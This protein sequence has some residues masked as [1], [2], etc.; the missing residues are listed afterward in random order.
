[1]AQNKTIIYSLFIL[2]FISSCSSTNQLST[3]K[4]EPDDA[5]PLTYQSTPS[6]IN[7]PITVQIKD[8]ENQTNT[9]LKGLIYED[10]DITDDDIEM[11]VWKTASIQMRNV[12]KNSN[13]KLETVLPLKALIKYRIGTERLGLKMYDVR[14]F[15]LTGT[16]ILN[17]DVALNNWKLRTKTEIKSL[18]WTESPTMTVFGKNMPITYL[19]NP[20][21]SLFKS[22]ITTSI[23]SAIEKAMDFKPNVLAALE[24]ICTPFLMNEDYESWLRI[25]PT[26]IY[27]TEA[28]IKKDAFML[29][30]GVKCTMETIIGKQPESKFNAANIAI[31]PVS[32]IPKQ[33]N[34]SIAAISTYSAASKIMSKNFVGQE[35]G[36]G[37]KKV[38]VKNVQLWHKNGK[39][40][41]ALDLSGSINGAIYLSG[42]PQYNSATKELYFDQLDYVLDT[43][44]KLT[45]T[46]NWLMQ[47]YI[48]KKIQ[49]SCRYSIAPNL[50]EGKQTMLTYLN[51]YSPM[52]GVFV[53][54]KLNEIT[55]DKLKLT[56]QAI[57]AFLKING[58]V[59]ISVDGLE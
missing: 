28:S 39:M 5:T 48:L 4:P 43:K 25:A 1:M 14:E 50:E 42:F 46:A 31:K 41:I 44:N 22:D 17:S 26:E 16:V 47:G 19:A 6:F 20:A 32:K 40:I 13:G 59:N 12:S 24:Q 56:N 38:L 7:L 29:E 52:K 8:I 30:M 23:D 34:A 55:F 36:S 57:I 10:N 27:S 2:L 51:N 33:V 35:F 11:K 18:V 53:N 49:E 37:G 3:L 58:T 45:R 9:H 15:N 54:G 21:I